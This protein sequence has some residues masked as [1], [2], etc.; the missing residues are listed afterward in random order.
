MSGKSF[1]IAIT[2]AKAVM[3][4]AIKATFEDQLNGAPSASFTA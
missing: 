4:R 2:D 3:N 1:V